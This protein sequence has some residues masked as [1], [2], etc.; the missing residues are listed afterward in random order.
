MTATS[1]SGWNGRILSKALT[2]QPQLTLKFYSFGIL[3]HKRTEHGFAEYVVD[4][5]QVAMLLSAQLTVDTGI[6]TP[7]TVLVR[8]DGGASV[9]AGYRRPQMTGIYLDGADGALRVPLPGLLLIRRTVEGHRPDYNVYAIKTRPRSL[10][11]A[12]YHAPLPNVYGTGNICWG[13]V[14]R[15]DADPDST[16][17]DAD[18]ASLLGSPFGDHTVGGKSRRYPKDVRKCLIRLEREGR[19][20]YP[21]TDLVPCKLTLGRALEGMKS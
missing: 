14:T 11:A 17:L 9:I 5:A 19:S 7:G 3:L 15:V 10:D 2:E 8:T 6:I 1:I 16:S 20:C 12:L 21:I 13:S 4:P 18:W